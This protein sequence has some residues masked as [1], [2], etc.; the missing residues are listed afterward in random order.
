MKP[1]SSISMVGL[2]SDRKYGLFFETQ[3]ICNLYKSLR[4]N[5]CSKCSDTQTFRTFHQLRDHTRK[6]HDLVYCDICIENLKLFPSEFKAYTRQD[7]IRHRRDGDP[8][9]KSHKGHPLCKFCDERYLD[10]D[11]LHSHLRKNHFWCHFCENDGRQE[12]YDNYTLLRQHF[13]KDHYLC[14]EGQCKHEK[15]TSVF[16]TK[17]DLQAHRASTHTKGLSKAE[18]K[19]LRQIDVGF[20]YARDAD[21]SNENVPPRA[22]NYATA[23]GQGRP[24][25]GRA[26]QMR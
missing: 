10:N 9:D 13:K 20:T 25:R 2:R 21:D 7:L 5:K 16:R 8:D 4:E 1:F 22:R 11:A 12:Y 26:V 23:R 14:E 19:Q 3:S 18:A 24:L 17:L 6:A 15:F